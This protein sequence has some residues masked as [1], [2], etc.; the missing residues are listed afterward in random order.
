M[1]GQLA[2]HPSQ[3][4]KREGKEDIMAAVL[5]TEHCYLLHMLF[6]RGGSLSAAS[7]QGAGN[8][9]Y[10]SKEELVN[11]F[12]KQHGGKSIRAT[13]LPSVSSVTLEGAGMT[14]ERWDIRCV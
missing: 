13:H 11:L 5:E 3:H 9:L 4:S 7:T 14:R 8:R 12:E 1:T 2:S 10:L 6:V